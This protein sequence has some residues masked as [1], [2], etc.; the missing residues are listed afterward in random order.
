MRYVKLK[1]SVVESV[2]YDPLEKVMEVK[3]RSGGT[4]RYVDVPGTVYAGM[5]NAD[6]HGS[7]V[8]RTLRKYDGEKLEEARD[9]VQEEG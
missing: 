4:Y 9:A 1:S 2:G 7:F 8:H 5:M 6:S 3:F